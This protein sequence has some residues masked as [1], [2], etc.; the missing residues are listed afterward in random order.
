MRRAALSSLFH[1][2]AYRLLEGHTRGVGALFTL[3]Q[4]RPAMP[5]GRF[6]PNRILEITPGFL[7]DTIQLI[8]RLGYQAVSLDECRRRLVERD[9]REPFVS[10]TLDDGY[11][12]NYTH[13][14]PVFSK[15]EVP[16]AIYL[17]T[18]LLDGSARQWWRDLEAIVATNDRLE[19][20]LEGRRKELICR[21]PHQKWRAFESVYWTL[22]RM[23]HDRQMLALEDLVRR[24]Q[25]EA[26]SSP[27]M[28]SLEMIEAMRSSGLL[29]VG[30]H[31]VTHPALSKL[32]RQAL[33]DEMAH[34]RDRISDLVGVVPQHFSYPYGDAKSAGQREFGAARELGFATGVTNRKHAGLLHAL[35]R[36]SLNGDYQRTDFVELF[37]TGVPF[38]LDPS[39]PRI[40]VA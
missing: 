30:A 24:Y 2:R 33:F 27:P 36:I 39:L 14:F 20:E 5:G 12:D 7:D 19:V 38:W 17:S 3:H 8:K 28:L 29:T 40:N 35:P 9:F 31:T 37:L 1:S 15:H 34:S 13:A 6:A 16:F 18:G 23:P 22:R 25:L 4:V 10:F 21:S 11:R 32:P 26:T